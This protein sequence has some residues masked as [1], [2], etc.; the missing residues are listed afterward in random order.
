MTI[1]AVVTAAG[2]GVRLGTDLPKA[3]VRVGGRPLVTW[4]IER[5]A[6]VASA[7]VVT[8][9]PGFASEFADAIAGA[10][11]PSGCD[12][13]AIEGGGTRQES[14]ALGVAELMARADPPQIILIH[15]AARAFMPAEAM[16][17]AVGAV[18][19]GAD[20]A[21]P[22]VPL[23]DTVVLMPDA[24]G[25]L[26]VAM[27]REAL[28]AAQ[29]PQVFRASAI[30]E[31][32]ILAAADGFA[33]AT[34]DAALVRRYG[35]RVVATEGHPWGFKVTVSGDLALAEH[36]AKK[37]YGGEAVTKPKGLPRTG[38]GVDVHA[39]GDEFGLALAGLMWDD[40]RALA[41]HSDGDVAAHAACDALLSAAGLGDLGSTFGV[42]RPEWEGA[43]GTTLLAETARL[44]RDAGFEIGNVAIQV[45][46]NRPRLG[47]RRAE[48]EAALSAAIG[49]P[50]SVSGTSSDGLGL[51]GR[52][53]GIAAVASAL[54]APVA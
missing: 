5:T 25:T 38:V 44:V 9:P 48:A 19:A 8:T 3:L 46:A 2:L 6:E 11:V 18:E 27:D 32:H 33:E 36:I 37:A 41:G 24:D 35:H 30:H 49:A 39:Y 43:S 22:I 20:G 28:R 31:A 52:G 45:I 12:I 54:I 42:D 26:G 53:E 14:V 4:A 17:V 15:D 50:V 29:T 21:V 10:N 23:V 40:E 1:A 13:T 51:A 16:R 7:I 47:G 34:D